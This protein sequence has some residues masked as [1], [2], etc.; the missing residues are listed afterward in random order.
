MPPTQPLIPRPPSTGH[1]VF[2]NRLR[3]CSSSGTSKKL[4]VVQKP[5]IP[6]PA[7]PTA[8]QEMS[9]QSSDYLQLSA[10]REL[11]SVQ[12]ACA[13]TLSTIAS[14]AVDTE[15]ECQQREVRETTVK[16]SVIPYSSMS[17]D[18]LPSEAKSTCVIED[19]VSQRSDVNIVATPQPKT[20]SATESKEL[21]VSHG[22]IR[23]HNKPDESAES[24]TE[25]HLTR[26]ISKSLR[27]SGRLPPDDLH[28]DKRCELDNARSQFA[29]AVVSS[30][31][32][33]QP[34]PTAVKRARARNEGNIMLRSLDSRQSRVVSGLLT[35]LV[36]SSGS[37]L[38]SAGC[39]RL[40]RSGRNSSSLGAKSPQASNNKVLATVSFELTENLEHCLN[41]CEL[42]ISWIY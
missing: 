34:T 39:Y 31:P 8:T 23:R 2:I 10:E 14:A 9:T 42:A 4:D 5:F 17:E 1:P 27:S 15:T 19:I 18:S 16:S 3:H 41:C 13:D 35:S 22:R 36:Q 26:S 20:T 12:T 24:V 33:E 32:A 21:I 37:R 29:C 11:P 40:M 25:A 7:T 38:A 30:S 28:W 6:P